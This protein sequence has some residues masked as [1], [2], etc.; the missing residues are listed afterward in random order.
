MEIDREDQMLNAVYKGDVQFVLSSI[1]S[2]VCLNVP[3]T[4]ADGRP[5]SPLI[6]A[7]T[8]KRSKVSLC[9]C[10][11]L[12]LN[13][14][15]PDF[16]VAGRKPLHEAIRLGRQDIVSLLLKS[17]ADPYA[18][19]DQ[20]RSAFDIAEELQQGKVIDI[21]AGNFDDVSVRFSR[22]I[23]SEE[24]ENDETTTPVGKSLSKS[25]NFLREVEKMFSD[26]IQGPCM[27]TLN[28]DNDNLSDDNDALCDLRT[29][30][31][32]IG[33]LTHNPPPAEKPAVD[34]SL[35][36]FVTE[37]STEKVANYL[38]SLP[39]NRSDIFLSALT[40]PRKKDKSYMRNTLASSAKKRAVIPVSNQ[41]SNMKT[42]TSCGTIGRQELICLQKT[43]LKHTNP[44]QNTKFSTLESGASSGTYLTSRSSAAISLANKSSVC[45]S[46]EYIIKDERNAVHLVEKRLPSMLT[47]AMQDENLL[48]QL[49]ENIEAP[50][51]QS[52][53]SNLLSLGSVANYSNDR[54]QCELRGYGETLL[55]PITSDTKRAYLLRLKKLKLGLSVPN[56]LLDSKYPKPMSD[57]LK[58][59]SNL[60]RKWKELWKLEE[61]MCINFSNIDANVASGIN[62][63]T[64]E[65]VCK[66]SFNYLLLDPRKSQNLPYKVFSWSDQ[67]LWTTFVDSIFYIGK[68]TRSRPFQHLYDASKNCVSKKN[69]CK[70][71]TIRNI[72]QENLGVVSF[73]AF[74][75]C[76]AVEG[77]TREAA[78][79]DAIGTG[80]L[81]NVKPGDYYGPSVVWSDDQKQLLGTFLL[82]RAFKMF[83][84][85]GERQ[86]RPVD[87]KIST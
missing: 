67:D 72:W 68:G 12:L 70:V 41:Y 26:E 21:L 73:Q 38:E 82:Y 34:N 77:F 9:M 33:F 20:H 42:D 8:L 80:N 19:D 79:I 47:L 44:H 52:N 43:Q 36:H 14:A 58:N 17:G 78:M 1:K 65:S 53:Q 4:G 10:Q 74:N 11:I 63:L 30:L 15:D 16:Q 22:Y 54:I 37:G 83:L 87:L 35:D 81:C 13:G 27:D 75:N 56:C 25:T 61:S 51:D 49:E 6:A 29:R 24:I 84:Q 69:S 2:G 28:L 3:A 45:I 85:E 86:I 76:I 32:E 40:T 46:E 64:R 18:F 55:G 57:S 31:M 39:E 7:T 59:V 60:T 5:I 62:Y 71:E 50:D 66:T 23:F 48:N